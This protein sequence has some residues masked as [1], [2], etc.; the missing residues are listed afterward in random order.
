MWK[1]YEIFKVLKI[2]KL[3]FAETIHRNMVYGRKFEALLNVKHR[4]QGKVVGFCLE[5]LAKT[6]LEI[7]VT[8]VNM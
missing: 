3:V 6:I 7:S 1:L 2:Q 5:P 4:R 8:F